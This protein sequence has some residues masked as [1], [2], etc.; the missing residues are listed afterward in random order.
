M[1]SIINDGTTTTTTHK[2]THTTRTKTPKADQPPRTYYIYTLYTSY[3]SSV[4]ASSICRSI[5]GSRA[6]SGARRSAA[7]LRAASASPS[8]TSSS[9]RCFSSPN[10]SSLIVYAQV[11]N[12]GIYICAI[13]QQQHA[14]IGETTHASVDNWIR[15]TCIYAKYLIYQHTCTKPLLSELSML[16]YTHP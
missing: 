8:R 15:H 14:Y 5:A 6:P 13:Q 7:K 12:T 16:L 1:A 11:H 2:H 10:R 3:A 4:N 9:K